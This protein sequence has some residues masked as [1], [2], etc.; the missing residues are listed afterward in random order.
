VNRSLALVFDSDERRR[1]CL[2]AALAREC[3]VHESARLSDLSPDAG[4]VHPTVVII[5]F[6]DAESIDVLAAIDRLHAADRRLSVVLVTTPGSE[7][8]AIAALRA[9]VKDYLRE[10]LD[11]DALAACVRRCFASDAS[12]RPPQRTARTASDPRDRFIGS[13]GA[14]RALGD[15]LVRVAQ[16]EAT[17]LI[18]GETGTGKELVAERIHDYS[19]RR[20]GRF[21]S[22]NCAAI[23]ESLLESELFGYES[24][25]FTGAVRAREGLLQLANRGTI[26]LDEVGDLALQAQAKLLRA[27]ETREV[28]RLGGTRPEKLDVRIVAA[29]NQDLDS[30]LE[31]GRF[32]KD[33][34]FRLNV[35][36]I[37]LPPLRERRSDIVPLLEHYLRVLNR[38]PHAGAAGF[39]PEAIAALQTYD[40]PGNVR[41]LKNLVEAILVSPRSDPLDIRDLPE[42]FRRRLQQLCSLPSAERR[43]LIDALLTAKWNKSKAATLLH[44]SRMTLY[45][46]MAKYSVVTSDDVHVVSHRPVTLSRPKSRA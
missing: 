12:R 37:H 15:Q 13:S 35:A 36:R 42:D 22:V 46:K 23:P 21:V 1:E 16:S 26:F 17:V 29:T 33:L 24:G 44:C 28:H 27:I 8:T 11:K 31:A 7:D 43:R 10:P 19:A 6:R 32:R 40:W 34:Y 2:S 5:G 38:G 14:M 41:E 20:A 3:A 39:S 9:G 4:R 18:T 45:R 25:A 30:A